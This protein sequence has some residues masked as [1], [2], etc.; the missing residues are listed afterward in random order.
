M[1]TI[2]KH[3]ILQRTNAEIANAIRNQATPAY[4]RRVPVAT[5]ANLERTFKAL[6]DTTALRNEFETAFIQKI[7]MQRVLDME[8]WEN[9]LAKFKLPKLEYG[10]TIEDIK[11]GLIQANA[12]DDG[13]D[14]LG[15]AVFRRYD[16]RVE[17][18][19]H[20]LNR[21]DVYPITIPQQ[22]LRAAFLNEGGLA[23]YTAAL[24]S[25]ARKSDNWD[26]FLLMTSLFRRY[27]EAD[28][29]FKVN[30]ADLGALDSDAPQA[31]A[32]LRRFRETAG[33]LGF[34]SERYNA[35]RMPSHIKPGE[36]ELF[37]TPEANAAIDVEALAGMFNVDR[38]E[39]GFHTTLVPQEHFNIPG[40]QAVLTS[41]DFFV[42][43]DHVYETAS[44]QNPANLTMQHFLHHQQVM[45]ASRFVP[46][47]L[48]TTDAGTS[49]TLNPRVTST[50]EDI[51]VTDIESTAVTE[52]ERGAAYK[53]E[54]AGKT[55]DG[56]TTSTILSV[57]GAEHGAT[58]VTQAGTLRISRSETADELVIVSKAIDNGIEERT[59]LTVVGD[60][61]Y[62]WPNPQV[63]SDGDGDGLDEVE[64]VTPTQAVDGKVT[65]PTT[66]GV[67]YR[68]GA[69]GSEANVA[70]G[71]KHD[72][73]V[74]VTAIAR[75][76]YELT[77]TNLGPWTF[78]APETN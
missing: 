13:A 50:V 51:V 75:D 34:I 77:G 58:F 21:K 62:D 20:T 40:A 33:N 36:L 39:V 11:V 78:T 43:A 4:Q 14:Y 76:G 16:A 29:F 38:G 28:G 9:P 54:S 55:A 49:V 59:T 12:L 52:V 25:A 1:A 60:I 63:V 7:A 71:T 74:R 72:A 66:R 27:E 31:K 61:V 67:Q 73:P 17:T 44:I 5:D 68:T 35:A 64:P 22:A 19:Y 57:E 48:F 10:A 24:L 26:E 32:A 70:N 69:S 65:I 56:D 41:P 37:I 2:P 30:V 45:S 15:D 47:V 23:N 3:P 6:T 53:V 18:Q 46:A 42:V 8:E